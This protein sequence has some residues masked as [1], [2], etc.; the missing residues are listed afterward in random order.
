MKALFERKQKK[1]TEAAQASCSSWY[2][3][4]GVKVFKHWP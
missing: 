2:S 1:K 4:N 3:N